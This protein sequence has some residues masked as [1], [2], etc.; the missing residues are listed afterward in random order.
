MPVLCHPWQSRHRSFQLPSRSVS[1]E[2]VSAPLHAINGQGPRTPPAIITRPKIATTYARI[3]VPIVGPPCCPSLRH[4]TSSARSILYLRR[5]KPTARRSVATPFCQ[6]EPGERRAVSILASRAGR[7]S[8]PTPEGF[9]THDAAADPND[10]CIAGAL[11]RRWEADDRHPS[12]AARLP[13][14][15]IFST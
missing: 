14:V 11:L 12:C 10:Q 2:F 13:V 6:A 9:E 8:A 1:V 15:L 7:A 3:M 5:L 4:R